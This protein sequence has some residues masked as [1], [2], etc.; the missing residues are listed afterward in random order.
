MEP[1][2]LDL[3]QK[4]RLDKNDDD[5]DDVNSKTGKDGQYTKVIMGKI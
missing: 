5:D 1:S 3:R 4:D 2:T